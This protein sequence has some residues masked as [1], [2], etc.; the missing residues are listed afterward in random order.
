MQLQN[1]M[2]GLGNESLS[3]SKKSACALGIELRLVNVDE[4]RQSN[5][6]AELRRRGSFGDQKQRL[7]SRFQENSTALEFADWEISKEL[8]LEQSRKDA[9]GSRGNGK[10]FRGI[11]KDR[12][13]R[14][15]EAI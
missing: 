8:D 4:A 9:N 15:R 2:H 10:S 13:E 7:K 1:K 12:S 14:D 6:S 11:E 5:N 3:K